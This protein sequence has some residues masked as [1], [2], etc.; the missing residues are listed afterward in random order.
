LLDCRIFVVESTRMES[1]ADASV[2]EFFRL[3]APDWAHLVPVTPD[4]QIVMIRQFRHGT[5]E[6][7]LEV[8]AGL[9]EPGETPETAARREC[10]EETGYRATDL[11][12]LGVLRPN[13][14]FMTN[15]LHSFY[16]LG[17][18]P[19]S[20]IAQTATEITE[21]ELVPIHRLPELLTSG[22]IDHALDTAL[23]WRFLHEY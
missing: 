11:R 17:V 4:E 2:H 21:V 8:P 20:A 3:R 1:P 10:L 9:I 12:S 22:A 16:A 14:A 18:E 7:S 15:R 5:Q 13:P 19:A 23:L 6:I